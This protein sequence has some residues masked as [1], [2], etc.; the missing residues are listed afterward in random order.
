MPDDPKQ[1]GRPDDVRIDPDQE[2]ELAYWS[3][4]LG[5][6]RDELRRAIQQVGP[7]VRDVERHL[8]IWHKPGDHS[9]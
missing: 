6:S 4:E 9:L 8:S 3:K 5:V 1:T 7:M 2:H